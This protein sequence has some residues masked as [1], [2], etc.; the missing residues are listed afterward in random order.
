MMNGIFAS[1]LPIQQPLG[2][3]E[4]HCID[5]PPWFFVVPSLGFRVLQ[6]HLRDSATINHCQLLAGSQ[7]TAFY[8]MGDASG[9]GF[10]SALWDNHK[11]W[12]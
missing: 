6:A 12:Y 10:S 4:I 11:I 8:L 9:A 2:T 7:V 5:V 1:S 3:V